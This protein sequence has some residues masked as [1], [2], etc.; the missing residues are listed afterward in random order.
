M[1]AQGKQTYKISKNQPQRKNH[2]QTMQE[3]SDRIKADDAIPT[4]CQEDNVLYVNVEV[5][6][7]STCGFFGNNPYVLAG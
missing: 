6:S 1:Y 4:Q 7:W 3:K 2:Q 5:T